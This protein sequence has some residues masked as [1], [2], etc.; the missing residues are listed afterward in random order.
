MDGRA[1]RRQ[2]QKL[3]TAAMNNPDQESGSWLEQRGF[4]GLDWA[5]QKHSVV[6]V[7]PQGKAM[8]DFEIEH[9]ALVRA[10]EVPRTNS[11]QRL[12]SFCDRDKPGRGRL[13][14][15]A[16][17]T[18]TDEIL[19]LNDRVIGSIFNKAR[20]RCSTIASPISSFVLK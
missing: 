7:E 3:E 13:L 17:A 16:G 11:S 10:E 4:G 8:E 5:S 18:L 9:S 12:D 2:Q 20:R 1:K 19:D 14:L 15:E 6:V